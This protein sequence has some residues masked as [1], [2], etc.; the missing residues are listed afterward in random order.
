M[1]AGHRR[2]QGG[3]RLTDFLKYLLQIQPASVSLSYVSNDNP[4]KH[5]CSHCRRAERDSS[6]GDV[7]LVRG[8]LNG[9]PYRAFLCDDHYAMMCDDGLVARPQAVA[10]TN[11]RA[12]LAQ[13]RAAY[14][15]ALR[16][17]T[18]DAAGRAKIGDLRDKMWMAEIDAA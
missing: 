16:T 9:R 6:E 4:M 7:R 3:A 10:V 12:L 2:D 1:A 17:L 5:T 13:A 14:E 11:S 18:L 8:K 15:H